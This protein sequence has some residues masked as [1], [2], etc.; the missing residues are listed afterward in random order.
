MCGWVH[1][2]VSALL[3]LR[4][5]AHAALPPAAC[6]AVHAQAALLFYG[7]PEEER[8]SFSHFMDVRVARLVRKPVRVSF[9]IDRLMVSGY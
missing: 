4:C 8:F 3:M 7:V 6:A 9:M 5:S 2:Q 1:P